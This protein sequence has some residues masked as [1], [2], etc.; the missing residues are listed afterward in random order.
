MF[1]L[2]HALDRQIDRYIKRQIDRQKDR[3]I[4]RQIDRQIDRY[5]KRQVDRFCDCLIEF[6][7]QEDTK[8]NIEKNVYVLMIM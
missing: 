8:M 3:K 6:C 2:G 1:F 5:I 7:A 4:N